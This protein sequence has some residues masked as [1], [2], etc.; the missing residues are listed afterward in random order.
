MDNDQR[1]AVA[2]ALHA[3]IDR[4]SPLGGGDI[5]EAYLVEASDGRRVFAKCNR[6]APRSMFP[7]EARGLEWLR[8]ADAVRVPEDVIARM[9]EER[10][11]EIPDLR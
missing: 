2:N 6:T 5:N 4:V 7:C 10:D 3:E 1:R 8:E 11:G 9:R